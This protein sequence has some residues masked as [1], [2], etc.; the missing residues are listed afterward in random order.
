M[1]VIDLLKKYDSLYADGN[2]TITDTQYDMLKESVRAQFPN[3]PYFEAVGSTVANGNKISLPFV[4]GSLDKVKIDTVEKWFK[5]QNDDIIASYKMDGVS[6]A[7]TWIDGSVSSAYTRGNGYEGQDITEKVKVFVKD[8]TLPGKITMRG[9]CVLIGDTYKRLGF[10]NRRN[11]VAGLLNRDDVTVEDLKN[12]VPMFYEIIQ[13]NYIIYTEEERLSLMNVL[14]KSVPKWITINKDNN[15]ISDT[16]VDLL[17]EAKDGDVDVD[18]IVLTK[19]NSDREN[20]FYPEH[21]VA[22]KVNTEAVR[23]KVTDVTWN[24][25][26]TGRITPLV[27]VEPVGL[28][29]VT[30]SKA[31]G[32][33]YKFIVDNDLGIG[34]EIGIVRSGDVIPF[35]TEIYT[36]GVCNV[37]DVCPSCGEKVIRSGVDIVCKNPDCRDA[38]VR[39]I[40]HFFK[41]LGSDYITET[42]ISNLGVNSIEEMYNLE[43]LDIAGIDGF[44][45]KKAEQIYYEIQKTLSITSDLLLAAF[46]ISGIGKTLSV[47]ILKKYDFEELFNIDAIEDVDGV[48]DILSDNLVNNINNFRDLYNF[49]KEKGLRFIMKEKSNISGKI[50]TLTGA[51]PMKRDEIVKLIVMKGGIVKGI[52]KST[53]FLVTA[54]T[55]SGSIKNQK[56]Q[57]YGTKIIDFDQLMVM[58]N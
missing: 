15:L 2:P 49:L 38:K 41:T 48:G 16:L 33:N 42:T 12:I 36:V 56:A 19:N 58:L 8:I 11:G 18:G 30:V 50:F 7:C 20:V 55:G 14:T 10:K 46:G 32:F 31:T 17:V 34:S 25:G 39:R 57:L 21:K 4:M 37:P 52:C 5:E 45:I 22:F 3:D 40:A 43:E 6:F 9:E 51:M 53:D 44:G 54:D 24:L 13:S 29:G 23:V 1:N 28:G 47:P 27:Y 26:R 35:I